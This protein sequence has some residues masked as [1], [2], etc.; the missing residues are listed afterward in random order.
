MPKPLL[1]NGAVRLSLAVTA[2]LAAS[3]ALAACSSASDL[4]LHAASLVLAGFVRTDV[5][6]VAAPSVT[7]PT[8]DFTAGI[9][10]S[11]L[12]PPAGLTSTALASTTTA[13]ARAQRA[14]QQQQ[15]AAA[16]QAQ[17]N[18]AIA[19][20]RVAGRIVAMYVSQGAH[21]KKGALVAKLDDR[22]LV[23]GVQQA[24]ADAAK[25][26][27]DIDVIS[28]KIDD[29]YD[30]RDKLL[31]ARDQ[32]LAGLAKIKQ[33]QAQLDAAQAKLDAGL[34]QLDAKQSQVDAGL[35]G[36]QA[37][38][39]Q[40]SSG[41]ASL[42]SSIAAVEA[43]IA[44]VE[45]LPPDKQPPG[46]L[47]KLKAQ[48]AELQSQRA[49]LLAKLP[50]LEAQLASLRGAHG[51]LTSARATAAA[52]QAQIDAG[53]AQL[54]AGKAQALAALAKIDDGIAKIDDGIDQLK[55]ARTIAQAALPVRDAAVIT[56]EDRLAAAT[57]TAPV[58]GQVV[59][60]MQTGEVLM[61]NA[62]VVKIR[63]D[64]PSRIDT[65]LTIAQLPLAKVGTRVW[66]TVDSKPDQRFA[67]T[68][69]HVQP[70]YT[71]PPTALPTTEVH[72]LRTVPV[73]LALGDDER[74]PAG[75]PVDVSFETTKAATP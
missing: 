45:K 13:N 44:E 26:R 3:L 2:A 28:A 48:L 32:V 19:K 46:L 58:S 43:Q 70:V 24:Q 64:G 15:Q 61:V 71:F 22:L 10:P 67:A 5:V 37:G 56:A 27:A 30:Q 17:A 75:T 69:T 42:D 16:Q 9:T 38:I 40:I 1:T 31:D 62:P 65:Y 52:G 49:A 29:L 33:G 6:Y 47:A 20:P 53:R 4:G 7:T 59:A 36:V 21:V 34:A 63:A 11:R 68:V 41:V 55:R 74:L 8:P 25:A 60:A 39:A 66:V 12:P 18:A 23:L 54:A 73:T 14:K 51:Q 50:P 72:L 57:I 35:E